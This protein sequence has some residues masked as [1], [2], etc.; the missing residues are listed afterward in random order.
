MDGSKAVVR[1]GRAAAGAARD[2]VPPAAVPAAK[3]LAS[4][5]PSP[6][7]A[8]E[9]AAARIRAASQSKAADAGRAG[10]AKVR[11]IRVPRLALPARTGDQRDQL[12]VEQDPGPTGAG[13]GQPGA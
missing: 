4:R 7:D 3:E 10:V 9:K 11:V 13:D 1:T 8:A 6:R 2:R 12:E 5:V